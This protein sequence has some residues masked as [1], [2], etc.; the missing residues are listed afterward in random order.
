LLIYEEVPEKA[1]MQPGDNCNWYLVNLIREGFAVQY[2]GPEAE[3]IFPVD[4][5]GWSVLSFSYVMLDEQMMDITTGLLDAFRASKD[6]EAKTGMSP[7]NMDNNVDRWKGRFPSRISGFSSR[8]SKFQ[9]ASSSMILKSLLPTNSVALGRLVLDVM[10]PEQDFCPS[11]MEPNSV[12]ISV[13]TTHNINEIVQRSKTSTLLGTLEKIIAPRFNHEELFGISAPQAKTYRLF[14]ASRHFDR[15]C[16]DAETRK[17]L[18]TALKKLGNVYM[19]IGISTMRDVTIVQGKKSIL[20]LESLGQVSVGGGV[21]IPLDVGPAVTIGASQTLEK[22]GQSGSFTA[23][24]ERVI[25]LQ[26]RKLRLK[27][28][29]SR[30][31][32]SVFLEKNVQWKVFMGNR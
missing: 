14:N 25:G 26:F 18:E 21:G 8:S 24:G 16:E 6:Q 2:K 27:L 7:G 11:S 3:T 19:I 28:F 22:R 23:L 12:D 10:N 32:D 13:T 20:G 9:T 29:S 31:L 30:S 4:I 1:P 5:T 17:W 15:M